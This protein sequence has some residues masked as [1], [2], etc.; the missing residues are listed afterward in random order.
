MIAYRPDIDGLRALA[1]AQ[2]VLYH[3]KFGVL[4]GGFAGVDVF[5]VISGYL[6]AS[7]ILSEIATGTFSIARFYERRV[8][9]IV[10]ALV[11]VVAGTL[12]AGA[13]IDDL[14]WD[15]ARL[16]ASAKA[17][18]A[19]Y[20]N[21]YFA[22]RTGY[23]VP[24][25]EVQPLLHTWSL[26]VEEQFYAVAPLVLTLLVRTGESWKR[27][28]IAVA[29]G[30]SLYASVRGIARA[31]IKSF[32]W[33]HA[34]AFELLIGVA[35]AAGL[36]PG[37]WSK[38][39]KD[40][41]AAVGLA[42][43]VIA[44]VWFSSATPFPGFAA[45]V[46]CLGAALIIHGGSET[47]VARM[48]AARPLVGL[49]KISYSLYLWH[50]PVFVFAG[51]LFGSA[52]NI[53]QRAALVAVSLALATLSYIFIEQ[54]F[55]RTT[56]VLTRTR[57]FQAA[58]GAIAICGLFAQGIIA[59]RGWPDRLPV[60]AAAF[61][62]ANVTELD[63]DKLC[64]EKP[65]SFGFRVGTCEIGSRAAVEPS[66]VIWGDSHARAL[67]TAVSAAANAR[68]LK[69][70]YLSRSA[71]V[72][73]FGFYD[74]PASASTPS[75]R[76]HKCLQST[77]SMK[78]L[79]DGH[80]LIR[81]VVMTARWG[82]YAGEQQDKTSENNDGDTQHFA[83]IL[84]QTVESLRQGGR[85]VEVIGPLPE[86]PFDIPAAM[87]AAK[88]KHEPALFPVAFSDFKEKNYRVLSALAEIGKIPLVHVLYPHEIFCNDKVCA[89]G[90]KEHAYFVDGDHLS[91]S[92]VD[93]ISG[94]IERAF[95]DQ[96]AG[97]ASDD[98]ASAGV[99]R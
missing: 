97:T 2:V 54:P 27:I 43:V 7:I 44:A 60:E 17:T 71:C 93:R 65:W 20:S 37:P 38:A 16:A 26:S 31:D 66:F 88:L 61:A 8:R 42:L 41:G 14:P 13:F 96:T 62:K 46:P 80:P 86:L 9:R 91:P 84:K 76:L 32:F 82:I 47:R 25:S 10:P 18:L 11:T 21:F 28:A 89:T 83:A 22:G 67:A 4:P 74:S 64:A 36:V 15:Y 23:F 73:L 51:Q 50:W 92:G 98:T 95:D 59:S 24:V 70:Y 75:A 33:P 87:L 85:T 19:F 1:I 35:V 72:P 6:I 77:E 5:F 49:G 90:D 39:Q 94:L 69:G 81:H 29:I 40:L 48:L 63:I 56:P 58:F 79:L 30:L 12:V 3:G 68:G 99:R 34:R 78:K 55:R 52:M 45:L 53:G 57:V